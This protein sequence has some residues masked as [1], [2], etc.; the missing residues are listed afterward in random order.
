ML[1]R[2]RGRGVEPV[3]AD[4][5]RQQLAVPLEVDPPG[6]APPGLPLDPRHP[7]AEIALQPLGDSGELGHVAA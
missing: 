3:A 7:A 4:V 5:Q 2:E 1:E 6:R